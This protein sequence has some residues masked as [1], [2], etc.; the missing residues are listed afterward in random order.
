MLT[1]GRPSQCSWVVATARR[2]D[3]AWRGE[4]L[5]VGPSNTPQGLEAEVFT[6]RMQ[7][8]GGRVRFDQPVEYLGVDDEESQVFQ[9]H[10]GRVFDLHGLP[11]AVYVSF[12]NGPSTRCLVELLRPISEEIYRSRGDRL[13]SRRHPLE[14]RPVPGLMAPGHEWP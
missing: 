2:T 10:P 3:A 13:V 6:G 8:V 4:G 11:E 7:Q 12:V 1:G 5:A 9:G 14:D